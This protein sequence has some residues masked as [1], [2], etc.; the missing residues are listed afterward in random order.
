MADEATEQ[1]KAPAKKKGKR[2]LI[3]GAAAVALLGGGGGAAYWFTRPAPATATGQEAEAAAEEE[4]AGEGGGVLSF[5]PFV[6]NLADGA[7]AR[8]LRINIRLVVAGEETATHLQEDEVAMVRL[9]SG[10]LELL[11]E[12]TSDQLVTAEGKAALKET[13]SARASEIIEPEK[14]TD[15]LFSDFLVQF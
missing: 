1:P 14:V 4:H 6:V 3:L 9:R 13:I 5:E 2:G 10:L 8:F 11:A 12:Q 15:V 7:G